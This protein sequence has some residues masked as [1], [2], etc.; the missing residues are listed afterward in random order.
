MNG[1]NFTERVRRVL[2]M[3]REESHGLDHEYVGTEH[4]LLGLLR[5]TDGVAIGALR[6]LNI[7]TAKVR[8]EVL[9][10]VKRGRP[11]ESQ[12]SELPYT[13]RAKKVLEL[14]MAETHELGHTYVGTEHLLLGLIR[15]EKGVAA[16]ALKYNLADYARVRSEIL[17]LLGSPHMPESPVTQES[18]SEIESVTI[19]IRFADGTL[20]QNV[21]K[22]IADA[23][24]HLTQ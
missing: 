21:F 15:E 11:G 23:A 3:A 8:R 5:E 1:Y 12:H 22:D 13:S 24:R 17:R 10:V 18:G 9:D 4:I 6:A 2:A 19:K 16:Q 14:S 20:Q 7:D